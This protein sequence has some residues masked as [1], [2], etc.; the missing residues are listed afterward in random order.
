METEEIMQRLERLRPFW[1]ERGEG[2]VGG[3]TV[4]GGEP[5]LQA[6]GLKE[7]L[8]AARERGIH[9]AVDTNGGVGDE[10]GRAALDEADLL[11]LD[12]KQ[13]REDK[14][15]ELTGQ[16]NVVALET[17]RWR[18]ERGKPMWLR[19]VLVPEWSSDEG[20]VTA[21]AKEL[22]GLKMVERVEILPFHQMGEAKY[23][24]LGREYWLKGWP[25]PSEEMKQ[26][27][28][29]IMQKYFGSEKVVLK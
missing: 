22:S 17:A 4:S 25:V 24:A 6:E 15:R 5:S 2:V 13:I 10:A 21:W 7:L 20:D 29:G 18:E 11:L 19:Y 23:E 28:K 8:M 12:V 16:S 26:R 27:T 9:T 1:R 3:L 14:H